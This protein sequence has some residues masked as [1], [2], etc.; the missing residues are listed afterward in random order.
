MVESHAAQYVSLNVRVSNNA[1]LRLYRDTLGFEVEKVE[2]KYYADGED[3]YA[4]RMDLSFIKDELAKENPD[5]VDE[6][7]EVGDVSAAVGKEKLRKVK[8]G[9]ALGVQD[10]QEKNE[11]KT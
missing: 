9:R 1:A 5:A 3:A 11:V 6:G 10:L 4:M 8:V 2:A 7:D